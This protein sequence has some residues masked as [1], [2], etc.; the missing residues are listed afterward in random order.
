V[1]PHGGVASRITPNPIAAGIPTAGEPIL[2][3]IS[4]ST[5]TNAMN[6]RI[7]QAGGRLPGP[8]LVDAAGRATNDPAVLF[9]DV[10]GAIL[11]LGGLDLGHKGFSLALI[12]EA[13]TSALSGHGRSE[14]PKPQTAS[15]F[16]QIVDPSAFGGR[17]GFSREMQYLVDLC[18][19]TPVAD[20]NPPVRLPGERALARRRGQ[21]R[22]GV[23]LHEMIL[24]ALAPWTARYGVEVPV[25]IT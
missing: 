8:W 18:R 16:L 17:D 24:P 5:S 20:G 7:A 1:T 9:A 2:I 11:P 6:K 21:I 25:P 4:A 19:E 3:D 13:L 22:D 23:S 14:R 10:P 15:I 12:V